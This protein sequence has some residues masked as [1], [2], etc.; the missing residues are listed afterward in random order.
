M[1]TWECGSCLD[2]FSAVIP[3]FEYDG[4]NYCTTCVSARI[5]SG[6]KNDDS[7][8]PPKIGLAP[9]VLTPE[10]IAALPLPIVRAYQNIAPWRSVSVHERVFCQRPARLEE[11]RDEL[12]NGWVGRKREIREDSTHQWQRCAVS[13]VRE[14]VIN[15]DVLIQSF[16]IDMRSLYL[17]S[18]RESPILD[19]HRSCLQ[20]SYS[21][22]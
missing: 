6:L 10:L 13:N 18:V 7:A 2:D 12:C 14:V 1:T 9:I 5:Q 21:Y 17:S 3:R 4:S 15:L 8:W 22:H 11:R 20:Q 19:H 16:A